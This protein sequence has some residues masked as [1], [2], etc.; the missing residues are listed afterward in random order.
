M[1]KWEYL[2]VRF[3]YFAG[4][5]C[6]H[7]ANGQELRNEQKKQPLYDYSNQM[8]EQGWE[9]LNFNFTPAYGYGFMTF[10]RQKQ[11]QEE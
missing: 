4:D 9:M 10:K 5:L 6:V 2:F 3:D 7:S 8:G 11:D 1:P